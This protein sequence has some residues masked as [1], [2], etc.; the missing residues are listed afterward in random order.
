MAITINGN[1]IIDEAAS[2]QTSASDTEPTGVGPDNEVAWQ[3]LLANMSSALKAE[4]SA[5]TLLPNDGETASDTSATFPQA[6]VRTI[7]S[8]SNDFIQ[9]GTT[10]TDLQFS[11]KDGNT[12]AAGTPTEIYATHNGARIFL[13]TDA[14]NNIVYGR[15]GKSNGT[16][17]DA[18]PS[19]KVAFAIVMDETV[20]GTNVTGGSVWTIQ[21]EALKQPNTSGIDDDDTSSLAGL[22]DVKATFTTTTE[23]GFKNF[24]SV[25]SGQDAWA[26]IEQSATAGTDTN[27]PDIIVSGLLP[28]STVN[29]SSTGL[30]S[31]SQAVDPGE[32]LRVDLVDHVNYPH[33]P[34]TSTDVHDPAALSYSDGSDPGIEKHVTSV[35]K[36][37]FSLVQVNPGNANTTASIK[38]WALDDLADAQGTAF[39]STASLGSDGLGGNQT[40][41]Q[42][43]SIKVYSD[44]TKTTLVQTI[45]SPAQQAD[46]SYLISGLKVNYTVEFTVAEGSHM[47]R[48]VVQ[49]NQP[50][51]GSGSNVSFDLGNFLFSVANSTSGTEHTA[52]GGNLLFEDDGPTVTSTGNSQTVTDDESFLAIDNHANFA[53]LFSVNYGADGA[54]SSPNPTYGLSTAGGT[55]NLVDTATGTTVV[56]LQNGANVVGVA[57]TTLSDPIVFVISVDSLTGEVT[58]DQQRAVVHAN[59]NDPNDSVTLTGINLVKLT[60][61]ATD[62]DGDAAAKT[63]D[64]TSSFKFLDDGPAITVNDSSGTYSAGAQGTWTEAPGADGFK[65]LSLALNSFEIDTHGTVTATP[66]NSS[67]TRTDNFHYSGSITA[68]FTDDGV[69][70]NQTVQFTLTFDPNAGPSPSYD[71][72]LTTPPGGIT[73]ISSADGSLGAGGPD[74]VQTLT[75]GTKKI[76]FSAV[77]ATAAVGDIEGNLDKTEAQ[78]QTNPLPSYISSAAMNVSTSGIGLANN[79]FD[80]N[81]LD[82]VD[83]QTTQGG[84]FDE[85]F[86]VDPTAFLVSSMKIFIDNSV[87]GYDPSTEGIFYRTYTRNADNTV[88]AGAITKVADTDL[89]SEA[90]GQKSFVIPSVDGKNDLDAVQL[91]MGSGT[92]KIPVIEFNISTTFNPEPLNVKFT[93]TIA[94]GD[95]DTKQD[96]FSIQVA[97]A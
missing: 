27:D 76:V 88:T 15:E 87:G 19:G 8:T 95:N 45:D 22:V 4:L 30:G 80:G 72:E 81:A 68:D 62:G 58:L 69:A 35:V 83:G 94:D 59:A 42:I 63:A 31:N 66:S 11:D 33:F 20:T 13:Y 38:L 93:A 44:L 91:F 50:L 89:T 46:G 60:A 28:G 74:P 43:T 5:L 84:A 70:N 97:S 65:S 53:G 67:L 41:Q 82:G 37:S 51:K 29:V 86:V 36:A 24:G 90:G 40:K 17:W 48:F 77:N 34:L 6:A 64:I 14:S 55:S 54:G 78:I 56:M 10:V 3:T 9:I 16:T 96:P 18:D 21:Y 52:I 85:S 92:V 1:L 2:V 61:T 73:K 49:N 23:V 39:F 47:D 7:G 12:I 26:A 75:I 79:N 25:P 57:G 32:G 71:F